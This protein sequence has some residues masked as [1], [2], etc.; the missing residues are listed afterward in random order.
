MTSMFLFTVLL[1]TILFGFRVSQYMVTSAGVEDA[2]AA[3]N[4]A[5]A[6]IDLEEYGKSHIICVEDPEAAFW[7]YREALMVNL[8]LDNYLNTTNR[9]FLAS[10][11]DILQYIVYNVR[12]NHI[13]ICTLD[14]KGKMQ[15]QTT[16]RKGNVF[17]PDGVQVETTTIYSKIGFWVNGLLEQEIYA[18]KEK[19]I[20]IMRCDSE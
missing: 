12:G 3:S 14:G 17:T 13:S 2:L 4:L 8:G 11:V 5:S 18:E 19:S 6:I 1:I 15:S 16:G 9:E 7:R 20:D 10:K